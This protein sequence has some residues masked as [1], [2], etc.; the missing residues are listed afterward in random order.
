M[1]L[2]EP[3]LEG[4]LLHDKCKSELFKIVGILKDAKFSSENANTT[5]LGKLC[6]DVEILYGS[7]P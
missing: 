2:T 3:E 1:L 5:I 4:A 6:S 7:T